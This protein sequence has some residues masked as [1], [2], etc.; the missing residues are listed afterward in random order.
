MADVSFLITHLPNDLRNTGDFFAKALQ[1]ISVKYPFWNRSGGSDHLFAFTQGQGARLAGDWRKVYRSTFLVHNGDFSEDHFRRGHDIVIPPNLASYVRDPA[2]I[3][4]KQ[5]LDEEK[6][7]F[8]F[9]GGQIIDESVSDHRGRNHSHGV[10]QFLK[11]H[12]SHLPDYHISDMVRDEH[13]VHLMS[14]SQF[15]LCPEGWHKWSPRPYYAVLVDCIPVV[16]SSRQEL[17]LNRLIAYDK[18]AVYVHPSDV[19][20]LDRKLRAISRGDIIRRRIEMRRIWRLLHYG[21]G[22]LAREAVLYEL[23]M[24]K[25]RSKSQPRK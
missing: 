17:A 24:R 15:C 10:R 19:H 12:L 20:D 4:R 14:K 18:F 13:Y 23:W 9:F 22:G 16:I 21:R 11:R 25:H 3:L 2:S 6:R 8:A 5:S 1:H 7:I